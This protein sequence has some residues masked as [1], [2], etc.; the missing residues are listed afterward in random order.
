[1]KLKGYIFSRP[2]FGEKSPSKCS[3]Y[4]FKRLLKKKKNY[5]LLLKTQQEYVFPNSS[6]ILFEIIDNLEKC[7]GIIFYSLMQLPINKQKRAS[8]I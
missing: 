1:M 8:F 5:S 7:D 4:Y 3:K 2:F 6:L